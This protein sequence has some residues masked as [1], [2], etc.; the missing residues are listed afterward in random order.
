[1]K[2]GAAI[3]V[4]MGLSSWLHADTRDELDKIKWI[5]QN[6]WSCARTVG[7][8]PFP[9]TGKFKGKSTREVSL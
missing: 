5:D 8:R 1:M 9:V 2:R 7:V 6:A 3:L 4:C